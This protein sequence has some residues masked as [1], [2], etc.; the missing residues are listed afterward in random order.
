MYT[1]RNVMSS[2]VITIGLEDT[3]SDAMHLMARREISSLIVRPAS[4]GGPQGIITKRDVLAKVVAS[5]LDPGETKVSAV[6][7]SPV[8]TIAPDTSLR[9]CSARMADLKVRRLPVCD[10]QNDLIGIVSETDI[11]AAVEERGWGPDQLGQSKLRAIG[12]LARIRRMTVGEV[13]S[14]PVAMVAADARVSDALSRMTGRGISSLIVQP[15][16]PLSVY[17]IVT[18][19]DIIGKVVAQNRDPRVLSVAEI[20]SAPIYTIQ[21]QMTLT[22]CA[23][24]MVELG[25]RR[26]TVTQNNQPVGIVSDTD[27]FRAV[28]GKRISPPGKASSATTERPAIQHITKSRVH[29]AADVMGREA[30]YV[31]PDATVS[32]AL[33]MMESENVLSLLVGPKGAAP[34][35]LALGIVTQRDI[36]SK[37]VAQE[38]DPDAL[39]VREISTT[40]IV[41]VP[42]DASINECSALMIERNIRR[43]PVQDGDDIIGIV[44]DT[45]IFAAVEERGWGPEGVAALPRERVGA[46]LP[47]KSKIEKA[48]AARAKPKAGRGSPKGKSKPPASI[49][50]TASPRKRASAPARKRSTR[51]RP[52]KRRGG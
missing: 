22:Q 50:S 15:Q 34:R 10:D 49:K 19:R 44:R 30:L 12:T 13:M 32:Q 37:V 24:R 47:P 8:V 38:R 26:L 48:Q 28:E 52:L 18:K 20:M 33:Q 11:F 36:I 31:A 9:E 29:T 14:Q 43:L 23:A 3:V 17:G 5:G 7:T 46:S 4:P 6:Y 42:P 25:V 2:P 21:P 27:I 35:H 41:T 40:P 1:V 16:P 45:D 39:H 51:Q